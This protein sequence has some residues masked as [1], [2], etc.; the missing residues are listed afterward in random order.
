VGDNDNVT[1]QKREEIITER[2]EMEE[3]IRKS[4][5]RYRNLFE[6]MVQGVLYYDVEGKIIS[7]NPAAESILGIMP[8]QM[9]GR[10]L[11]D[12]RLKAVH[13]DGSDFPGDAYPSMIALS[14]GQVIKD[15]IMGVLNLVEND[16]R[17]ININAIPQFM[18]GDNKPFQ[19]YTT[20]HDI[21]E[22]KRTLEALINT[23][24]KAE[25]AQ[26][27]AFMGNMAAGI[28][29]EINQPLNAIK[30]IVD[31]VLYLHEAGK[32]LSL[33]VI[34]QKL[35]EVSK[36]VDHIDGVIRHMKTLMSNGRLELTP[37]DLNSAVE[38]VCSMLNAQLSAHGILV[39]RK[40]DDEIPMITAEQRGLKEVILNLVINAMQALDKAGKENK[41][42]TIATFVDQNVVLE[43]SDNAR[44]IDEK[45]IDKIFD[46]FFTTKEVGE[47]MGLGL[48][49]VLS[50]VTLYQGEISV[51]NN[52]RGGATFLV[53]FQSNRSYLNYSPGG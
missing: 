42:I 35:E 1:A 18:Q 29:H 19:V 6:T 33:K 34:L 12:L 3:T 24:K 51:I 13:E 14:T 39:N 25:I 11:A 48:S 45:I 47:G 16:Y 36:Q 37:C 43:I 23:K 26:R 46:P 27:M 41:E 32:K 8:E 40:L 21:T 4:E 17:W 31:S 30:I 52:E 50:T 9:R 53:K 28:A 38:G 15:V 10:T 44:G 22:K 2:K 49:I 7:C 5:E 20:I